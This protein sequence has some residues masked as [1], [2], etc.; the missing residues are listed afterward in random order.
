MFSEAKGTQY[1]KCDGTRG[2]MAHAM[3]FI[4]IFIKRPCKREKM[5]DKMVKFYVKT[6]P[7][8]FRSK[9]F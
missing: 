8:V 1:E 9:N 2:H 3:Y 6:E 5:D 4:K 7:H